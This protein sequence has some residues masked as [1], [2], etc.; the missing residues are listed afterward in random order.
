MKKKKILVVEDEVIVADNICDV[1]T[2]LGYKAL[3]P[4]INFTEAV[5]LIGQEK[6]DLV[7]LD[8]QLSGKK[9]GIEVAQLLREKYKIPFIFLTSNSD[10]YTFSDA[11]KVRP[12][13]F[14][15]KP[16]KP[17]DLYSAIEI[18]FLNYAEL[19]SKKE[20]DLKP[21]HFFFK[22]RKGYEKVLEDD[23]LFIK[24]SHVY[25]EV[26]LINKKPLIIRKSMS[27]LTEELSD[28]FV[29]VHRSY[30]VNK[31]HVTSIEAAKTIVI[32]SEI[33]V[34]KKYKEGFLKAVNI[35]S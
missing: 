5:I 2:E 34:G 11:R 29:R 16:F 22:T 4:A 6:P 23:I 1:L 10:T 27:E 26:Y 35:I 17:E 19:D 18:A 24:S 32:H 8:I 12:L 9:S 3:E 7:I 30:I 20:I 33:P 13:A 21:N 25:V 14:L 28:S 15:V 31:K